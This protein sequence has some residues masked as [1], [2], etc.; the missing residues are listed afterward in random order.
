MAS[1]TTEVTDETL[2]RSHVSAIQIPSIDDD[3]LV[4]SESAAIVV[5][6]AKKS[7]RL[8]PRDPAR[9][10]QVLRWRFAAMNSVE[11]PLLALMVLE[12]FTDS[13]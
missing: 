4:L 7:G 8:I 10:A 11:P 2:L 3:G 1:N 9:E 12:R 6:L 5:Y 13:S